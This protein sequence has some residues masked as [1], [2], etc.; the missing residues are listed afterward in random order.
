MT[1]DIVAPYGAW[2]SPLSAARLATASA[3]I[4]QTRACGDRLLWTETRP[5]EGGR[6]ALLSRDAAGRVTEVLP[7]GFSVR[8]RV[9]EYGGMAFARAGRTLL[10]EPAGRCCSPTTPINAFTPSNPAGIHSR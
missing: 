1:S 8:T 7:A 6:V 5:A 3:S 2:T 4:G 10:R 9:H